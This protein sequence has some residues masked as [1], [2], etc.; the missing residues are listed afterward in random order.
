MKT[1]RMKKQFINA[2]VIAAI[3]GTQMS[4][5]GFSYWSGKYETFSSKQVQQVWLST[6]GI[7]G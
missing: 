1:A 3:I 2:I 7:R 5:L 4:C 6:A